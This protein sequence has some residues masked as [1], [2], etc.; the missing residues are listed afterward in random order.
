MNRW[1]AIEEI[2]KHS[3]ELREL[4]YRFEEYT[5]QAKGYDDEDDLKSARVILPLG[6]SLFLPIWTILASIGRRYGVD[7]DVV[8]VKELESTEKGVTERP[9]ISLPTYLLG[10]LL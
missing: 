2:Q 8:D 7:L 4:F 10:L 3:S 9:W 6:I 5:T 1:D